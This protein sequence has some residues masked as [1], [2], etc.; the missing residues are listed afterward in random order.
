MEKIREDPNDVSVITVHLDPKDSRVCDY[1]N[2]VLM[3]LSN[4]GANSDLTV[5]K[6][7]HSTPYGLLCDECKEDLRALRTYE[8]GDVVCADK[9]GN[10]EKSKYKLMS[11]F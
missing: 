7:C 8:A 1:C 11:R 10:I 4:G 5:R 3:E 9:S 2:E 6:R